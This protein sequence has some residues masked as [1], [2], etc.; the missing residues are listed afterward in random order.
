MKNHKIHLQLNYKFWIETDN[1]I[2][3]L[4]EGK[5]KLLKAIRETGSLKAACEQMGFAYRQTWENLKKIET[6]L[7]F[8]LIEKSRGGSKGGETNL[9]KKGE[10]L[11]DFFDKLYNEMDGGI[12]KKFDQ[13]LDDL[14]KIIE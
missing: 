5:W 9:T 2:N 3:L 14:N 6:K 1:K 10:M 8:N 7:G 11:V 4:G 13:M 12:R